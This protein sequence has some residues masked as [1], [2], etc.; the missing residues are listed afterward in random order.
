MA[1]KKTFSPILFTLL[2]T[3]C[4]YTS[5]DYKSF[6]DYP[7]SD[8]D[9]WLSYSKEAT[10]FRIWSPTAEMVQLK[11]YDEGTGGEPKALYNLHAKKDGTWEIKLKG[12]L[13]GTFYTY[14]VKTADVLLKETPGI[15]ARAVGINGERAMVVD[16]E[17]TNPEGWE[18]DKGPGISYP[19]EAVLYELHMRDL[20]V[21]PESGIKHKGKYTGL[22]EKGT[23]G[24][25]G[26]ATGLDH[27]LELGITH[28]HLLPVFDFNFL[29]EARPDSAQYNWGYNP[30]NYNTPEG[31]YSTDPWNGEVRIKEFKQMVRTLHDNNIGVIMDVVYNH[32]AL[33][34]H[35]NFNLEVPGYF[36]RHM[37]DGKPSNASACGNELASERAMVR[38]Y[39]IES[40]TYWAREY[41]LDGFRFDLMAIL[42]VETMNEI[43]AALKAIN[44]D[45]IIYGEGWSAG[46][47]PYPAEKRAFKFN[48]PQMPGI[49]A[50]SDE[51]RD[52]LKGSVFETMDKGFVNGEENTEESVK[53]GIVG[54]I[55]HPQVDYSRVN[56]SKEAWTTHPWQAVAYV[57]CHD[58]LTL[59]DKLKLSCPEA[60]EEDII[61]MDRL[62]IAVVLTSQGMAF[63][64][65]GS[66]LL[67][68]KKGVENSYISPDS[69][70]QIDW[71]RKM[72]YPGTFNYYRNLVKLRKEHPAFRMRTGEEVRKNLEF[73]TTENGLI[74]Y[75]ISNHANGDNWKNIHVIYNARP[76]VVIYELPGTWTVAVMGELFNPG[77]KITDQVVV[78]ARSMLIAY[79][80]E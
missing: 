55:E 54:C 51:I 38:K 41:H 10:V 21:Y 72:K 35:S 74:S 69:I 18:D 19:D 48:L 65:A 12:D 57:S 24:P 52:G 5:S 76:E 67:R 43:A 11:L 73:H 6:N 59:Y 50:F 63:L 64:H 53:M 30:F 2:L 60:T 47:S 9:L 62:A 16:L 66:E 80:E 40:V 14:Q 27:L 56:A 8:N 28:V 15:Y 42:D 32:T 3:S 61:A 79:Q 1:I 17:S 7:V 75:Q 44:Q 29:D 20:S 78:P 34:E 70:N 49:S 39:I 46:S 45:I 77:T 71:S 31:S 26:V 37:E 13:N 33:Y 23:R 58:N 4:N 22:A 68:S 36:Y 25:G